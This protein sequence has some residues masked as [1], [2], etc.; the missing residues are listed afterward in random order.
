MGNPAEKTTGHPILQLYQIP[1]AKRQELFLSFL[2]KCGARGLSNHFFPRATPKP[3]V[4][5]AKGPSRTGAGRTPALQNG[6]GRLLKRKLATF[7]RSV[8][9]RSSSSD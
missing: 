3:K 9:I 4:G 2:E 1:P 8:F 5:L 6:Q 7:L